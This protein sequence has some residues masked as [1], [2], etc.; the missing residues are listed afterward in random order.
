MRESTCWPQVQTFS[1]LSWREA[2]RPETAVPMMTSVSYEL[3]SPT[4]PWLAQALSDAQRPFPYYFLMLYSPPAPLPPP[5]AV[6]SFKS[7]NSFL[8][9]PNT[10]K[11]K[12]MA[13]TNFLWCFW[14][15]CPAV[16]LALLEWTG[17]K[18]DPGWAARSGM[19]DPA[20]V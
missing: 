3:L 17:E 4:L 9:L 18:R 13:V 6:S 5:P 12:C 15:F 11:K 2:E 19:C 16:G 8:S 1:A 10:I 7:L 20:W 14:R